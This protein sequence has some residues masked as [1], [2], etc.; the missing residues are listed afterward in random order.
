MRNFA[1]KNVVEKIR[2]RI[3]CSKNFCPEHHAVSEKSKK[4]AV[5]PDRPQVTI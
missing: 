4:N 5:Q 1:E 2:T 3:L